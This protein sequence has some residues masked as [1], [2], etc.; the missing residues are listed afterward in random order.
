MSEFDTI[1]NIERLFKQKTL[2]DIALEVEKFLDFMNI[3]VFP[4]WLDGEL[5]DGPNVGRYWITVTLRYEYKKMPDPMAARIMHDVGVKVD[6]KKDIMMEP[7]KIKNPEDF[8]PNSKKPKLLPKKIWH[9][10]LKIPRRFIDD[11][12]YND[13]E[14][15]DDEIDVD[16]ISDAADQGIA[17]DDLAKVNSGP[18]ADENNE[19]APMS[20]MGGEENV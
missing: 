18:E 7:I 15:I 3:Y 4:N 11:I 16:D 13:L 8:R 5:V 6:Y 10:E 19:L 20:G 17:D 12:D 1:K 14:E 2:L 9:V